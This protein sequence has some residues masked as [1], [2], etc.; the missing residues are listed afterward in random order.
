MT[1]NFKEQKAQEELEKGF[2]Q[3]KNLLKDQDKVEIFLLRLEEKLKLIPIAG[4]RL[5]N[6][7][8]MASLIRSFM[9]HEYTDIPIG[10]IIAI[11]SALIYFVSPLDL[12]PDSIPIMGYIDDAAV[13]AVCWRLVESDVKEYVKWRDDKA[14]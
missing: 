11:T 2:E 13:I 12:L 9:K 3:A 1:K 5:A 14:I 6:I 8:V 10:S 7:P 4:D